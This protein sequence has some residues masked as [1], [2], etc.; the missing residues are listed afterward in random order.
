MPKKIWVDR[1]LS[2]ASSAC[3]F[4]GRRRDACRRCT[5]A[6]PHQALRAGDEFIELDGARCTDC[7]DCVSACPSGALSQ[8]RTE[9]RPIGKQ[10]RVE[11]GIVPVLCEASVWRSTMAPWIAGGRE[12]PAGV[13]PLLVE[14]IGALSEVELAAV[15]Q[16]SGRGAVVL[17]PAGPNG[18]GGEPAR[19][20][21]Q[22]AA[23]MEQVT[24]SL[25]GRQLVHLFRDAQTFWSRI[26]A[27]STSL[28]PMSLGCTA[29]VPEGEQT[30]RARF[31][32]ILEQWLAA[33]GGPASGSTLIPHPAFA[34]VACAAE[35]CLMCGACA[36]Q[37]RVRA[38]R[39]VS[40]QTDTALFHDPLAC[41]N[42][43][44]CVAT[45][46]EQALALV[47]GLRLE[48]R[49]LLPRE[50][51]KVDGLR[52]AACGR[53]FTTVRRAQRVS[54]RLLATRGA[55]PVREELLAL[56]PECRGRRALF[57]HAEWATGR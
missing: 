30:K 52:C 46:P 7:G 24:A 32:S 17:A 23:F 48:R 16:V 21:V 34:T 26:P 5:E 9:R 40:T 41:L 18:R 42:C 15:V 57:A 31:G 25:F 27:V 1:G 20:Y 2:Y 51:C 45:C 56:C 33:A 55:D 44:A 35:K 49:A 38:L 11:E 10:L 54:A 39:A 43:G 29:P 13:E 22:A 37:C 3:Q 8:R 47:P 53:A 36:N 6:C 28:P 50:L 14:G 19:P 4:S 12:L